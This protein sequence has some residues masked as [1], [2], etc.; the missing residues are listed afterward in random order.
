M[1]LDAILRMGG[2]FEVCREDGDNTEY[3]PLVPP[4][5][6]PVHIRV[7]YRCRACSRPPVAEV[8]HFIAGIG[9]EA[10]CFI[11]RGYRSDECDGQIGFTRYA[12]LEPDYG[13]EVACACPEHGELEID[14][15]RVR[16][17]VAHSITVQLRQSR[18]TQEK[19][20]R[21]VRLSPL[22]PV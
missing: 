22:Q 9:V 16:R 5:H 14:A 12:F 6:Q 21:R 19:V 4:L 2:G 11:G 3:E 17:D 13:A 10:V 18:N 7:L 8:E 1:N 15:E 20:T